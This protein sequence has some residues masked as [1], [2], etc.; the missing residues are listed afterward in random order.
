MEEYRL[1]IYIICLISITMMIVGMISNKDKW[2]KKTIV[3]YLIVLV[4]GIVA[5]GIK[6]WGLEK[7]ESPKMV[8]E[9]EYK[10]IDSIST[11][12][13]QNSQEARVKDAY[14]ECVEMMEKPGE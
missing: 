6:I 11:I 7:Q 1:S 10:S 9:C 12:E 13:Q 5:H 8:L 4:I 3:G 14:D 2:R